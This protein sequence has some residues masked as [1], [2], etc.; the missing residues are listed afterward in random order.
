MRPLFSILLIASLLTVNAQETPTPK[1]YK[2][3]IKTG[4]NF[5]MLLGTEFK[6]P[7]PRFGYTAGAYWS[8]AF[9][10]DKYLLQIELLA[11]FKGS[12][13]ANPVGQYQSI[14]VFALDLPLMYGP[15]FK[16]KH[17]LLFGPQFGY[18]ALSSMFLNK[19]QGKAFDNNVGFT[20]YLLDG[21]VMYQYQAGVVGYQCGFKYS[22]LDMN[23]NVE[24]VDIFPATGTGGSVRSLSFE[25]ALIF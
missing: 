3:G 5:S 7:T 23:D 15:T 12:N 19:A 17:S 13:F 10:R 24:F 6:N 2:L 14:P 18:M 25:A 22:I 11:N 9:K 4:V 16:K 20:R 1:T 8:K 21:V